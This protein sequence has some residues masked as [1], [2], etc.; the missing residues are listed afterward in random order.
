ME[1]QWKGQIQG[2]HNE[3]SDEGRKDLYLLALGGINDEQSTKMN[4]TWVV[5]ARWS[6][7]LDQVILLN[8]NSFSDQSV[9]IKRIQED[10]VFAFQL[11]GYLKHEWLEDWSPSGLQLGKLSAEHSLS[12]AISWIK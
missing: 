3:Y 5:K 10:L 4:G 8:T 11:H 9:C 2:Y 6:R 1:S 12:E 7:L